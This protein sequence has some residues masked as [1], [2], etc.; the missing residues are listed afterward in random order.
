[1]P[2]PKKKKNN[3]FK[4]F[5]VWLQMAC[6]HLKWQNFD[7]QFVTHLTRHL[8]GPIH[9]PSTWQNPVKSQTLPVT[10]PKNTL[11]QTLAW[12]ID[13]LH[14]LID[15]WLWRL[16]EAKVLNLTKNC[17]KIWISITQM[18]ATKGPGQNDGLLHVPGQ[19]IT[20]RQVAAGWLLQ[21][22]RGSH[23]APFQD[24]T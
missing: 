18:S 20:D 24:F 12:K 8:T 1:M 2:P 9:I 15:I 19:K 11:K 7:K 6:H 5:Q 4:G 16:W 14:Y 22:G 13:I 17:L 3:Q 10:K 21:D 23:G